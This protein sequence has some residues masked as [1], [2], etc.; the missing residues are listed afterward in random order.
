MRIDLT[1]SRYSTTKFPKSVSDLLI[2]SYAQVTA[3]QGLVIGNFENDPNNNLLVEY[4]DSQSGFTVQPS[5]STFIDSHTQLA[6]GSYARFESSTGYRF[7]TTMV[8]GQITF[9]KT[10]TVD[11]LLNHVPNINYGACGIPVLKVTLTPSEAAGPSTGMTY[12]NNF[13]QI[14]GV[15]VKNTYQGNPYYQI[16][17]AEYLII[18]EF[19]YPV[20]IISPDSIINIAQYLNDNTERVYAGI[21][22]SIL[23]DTRIPATD[24]QDTSPVF[25]VSNNFD[26][27]MQAF[28]PD[29]DQ[30]AFAL[31]V[32]YNFMALI[33]GV[34][35]GNQQ[36]VTA[37]W[38]FNVMSARI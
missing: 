9:N 35:L 26:V 13:F 3:T 2:Y 17:N 11:S 6:M 33:L 36:T 29:I 25:Q 32:N 15:I 12:D 7:I 31:P 24:Y 5:D 8:G 28:T 21:V 18:D 37:S 10:V 14:Q 1:A 30:E 27:D 38:T 4:C 19:D 23:W 20:A 22:S 16:D 34:P